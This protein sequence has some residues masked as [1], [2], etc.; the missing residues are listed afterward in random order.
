M[1]GDNTE[2]TLYNRVN[3]YGDL[4]LNQEFQFENYLG[5][6]VTHAYLLNLEN[7]SL[8]RVNSTATGGELDVRMT[9][10]YEDGFRRDWT[11]PDSANMQSA[12][13]YYLPAGQYL[14]EMVI[15]NNVNEWVEFN[16]G[17]IVSETTTEIVDIGGFWFAPDIFQ[18]YNMTIFINNEDNV[19]VGL[20]VT[21]Y[22]G[23]GR[24]M[25]NA[26]MLIANRWDGSQIQPHPTYWANATFNY[27]GHDWSES[28]FVG[29]CAYL[30]NNNTEIP[31][32]NSY[33]DYPVDLTIQWTNRMN[34]YYVNILSL[35]VSTGP[36]AHN[37]TLPLPGTATEFHGLI[38]NTTPGTWYNVSVMTGDINARSGTLY[39]EYDGR[40]HT[41][42]WTDLNDAISGPT[43]TDYAFEIGAISDNLFLELEMDRDLS[44]DGFLWV[45]I[46]PLETHPIEF[47]QITP[48]GPD[49]FGVLGG[50]VVPAVIGVGVIVVVYIVYVK[51]FK[52]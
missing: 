25:Y 40:T 29:I 27:A 37:F 1:G 48:L 50:V 15:A 47:E 23:S 43:V 51:K 24:T 13:E 52:K 49:L 12:A 17:P 39:S 5:A 11:V 7:A 44:N 6:T 32:T 41:T 20:D 34:D 42:D 4:P 3:S 18:L 45:Q 35:D 28:A 26:G 10:L 9:G 22:D 8:L 14:V 33:Q 19:T 16:I 30:V 46:T 38:L 2:Y 36:A 21:I 31:A